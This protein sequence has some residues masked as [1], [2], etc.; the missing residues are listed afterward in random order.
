VSILFSHPPFKYIN[1]I[2]DRPLGSGRVVYILA[3]VGQVGL[4]LLDI[5]LGRVELSQEIWTNV[6]LCTGLTS[7]T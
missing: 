1:N 5:G 3:F 6:H 4:G 2:L 7:R